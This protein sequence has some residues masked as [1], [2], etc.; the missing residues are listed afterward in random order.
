VMR[1]NSYSIIM[2]CKNH[3]CAYYC[4]LLKLLLLDS[5]RVTNDFL[6]D[7]LHD[8]SNLQK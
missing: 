3:L 2:C 8:L 7:L 4:G 6:L 1:G 5:N